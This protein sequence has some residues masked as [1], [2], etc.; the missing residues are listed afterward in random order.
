MI[1]TID[2]KTGNKRELVVDGK[3]SAFIIELPLDDGTIE[4]S[5][6]KHPDCS[7]ELFDDLLETWKETKNHFY[8]FIRQYPQNLYSK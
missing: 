8:L 1:I 7:Q 4:M 2:L 5:L 3:L 6:E